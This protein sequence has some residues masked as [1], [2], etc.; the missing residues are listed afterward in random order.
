MFFKRSKSLEL[1]S[2]INGS[3][4]KIGLSDRESS[5]SSISEGQSTMRQRLELL[6][7]K[8]KQQSQEIKDLRTKHTRE[9]AEIKTKLDGKKTPKK[10]GEYQ[11]LDSKLP[12]E[13]YRPQ[14]WQKI[15]ALNDQISSIQGN[16][17]EKTRLDKI[18]S[19][20]RNR[21]NTRIKLEPK[22]VQKA[23]KKLDKKEQYTY[24][25]KK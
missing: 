3:S 23:Y 12:I 1:A 6:E 21:Y 5:L 14:Y 20:A 7:D 2:C 25:Y 18:K 17:K 11:K 4:V 9:I 16:Q 24:V 13:D 8:V 10:N 19:A 22:R 15:D